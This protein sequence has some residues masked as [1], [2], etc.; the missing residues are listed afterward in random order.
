MASK[1]RKENGC[2]DAG[3]NDNAGF[4]LRL[5]ALEGLNRTLPADLRVS[6]NKNRIDGSL[7]LKKPTPKQAITVK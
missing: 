4:L 6:I 2:V 1:S 5:K 7:E 3:A